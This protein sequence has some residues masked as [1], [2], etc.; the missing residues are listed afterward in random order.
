MTINECLAYCQDHETLCRIQG[1][2]FDESYFSEWSILSL[3]SVYRRYKDRRIK[4]FRVAAALLAAIMERIDKYVSIDASDGKCTFGECG[5]L[6]SAIMD[7]CG[8][9]SLEHRFTDSELTS[10]ADA[11]TVC[12]T[13]DPLDIALWQLFKDADKLF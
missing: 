6:L 1:I 12:P 8:A 3:I 4:S 7:Y 11:P 13:G 5:N 10:V 2:S 9:P